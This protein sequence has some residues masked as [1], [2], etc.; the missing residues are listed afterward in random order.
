MNF[1]SCFHFIFFLIKI[2][3]KSYNDFMSAGTPVIYNNMYQEK[4]NDF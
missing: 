2:G 1:M 3:K 4:R